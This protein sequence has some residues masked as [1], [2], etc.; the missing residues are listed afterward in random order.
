MA[1]TVYTSPIGSQLA[2]DSHGN[3]FWNCG[4]GWRSFNMRSK[5]AHKAIDDG[6]FVF[7]EDAT[8]DARHREIR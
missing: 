4:L 1:L 5:E 3:V 2:T 6:L 8:A 7:D